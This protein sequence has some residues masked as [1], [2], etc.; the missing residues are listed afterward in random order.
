M[1]DSKDAP[2]MPCVKSQ[3]EGFSATDV[4]FSGLTKLEYAAIHLKVTHKDL[5]PWLNEMIEQSRRDDLAKAALVSEVIK[6]GR[7]ENHAITMY[8]IADAVIAEGKK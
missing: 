3:G 5:S 8:E 2:V 7:P 1:S 4:Y 6:Y